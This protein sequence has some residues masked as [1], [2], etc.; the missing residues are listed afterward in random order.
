VKTP[1]ETMNMQT[2]RRAAL[3]ARAGY[4]WRIAGSERLPYVPDDINIEVTNS[5]NFQC[6]FCPQSSPTHHQASPRAMLTP[7]GADIL[8]GRLRRGGVR[9]GTIHWTLDGE[10]F[11]NTQFHSICDAAHRFGFMT[12]ILSTNG[13]LASTERLAKLPRPVGARY[14]LAVDFCADHGYFEEV[15]G[16]V[17]SW[18]RILTNIRE[19]LASPDLAHIAFYITDISNYR[20]TDPLELASRLGNSKSCSLDCPG[21]GFGREPSTMWQGWWRL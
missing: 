6:S 2:I 13:W 4:H 21:C 10:P 14:V 17:D 20:V 9:T 7:E 16:T 8:L 18:E 19:A 1:G 12:S 3:Y 15:R 11:V 5:C